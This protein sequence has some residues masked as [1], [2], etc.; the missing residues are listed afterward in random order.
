MRRLLSP[1]LWFPIAGVLTILTIFVVRGT[2]GG[3]LAA[4]ATGAFLFAC[5]RSL[6]GSK[7]DDRAAWAGWFGHYF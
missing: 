1:R 4:A 3:L 6:A 5:M 2:A 7:V